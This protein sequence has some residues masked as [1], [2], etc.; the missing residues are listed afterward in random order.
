MAT[1][2]VGPEV[3]WTPKNLGMGRHTYLEAPNF[4]RIYPIWPAGD[5]TTFVHY[6]PILRYVVSYFSSVL[7]GL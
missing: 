4:I 1:S 3:D 6:L 2:M 5:C 7:C